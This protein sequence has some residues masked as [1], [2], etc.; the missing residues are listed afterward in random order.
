MLIL[1]DLEQ[2]NVCLKEI[3]SSIV[4]MKSITQSVKTCKMSPFLMAAAAQEVEQVIHSSEGLCFTPCSQSMSVRLNYKLF[5]MALPS[6]S[7]LVDVNCYW[8]LRNVKMA[9]CSLALQSTFSSR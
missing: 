9:E 1:K 6:L 4:A 3:K 2:V 5:T 7:N 8:L